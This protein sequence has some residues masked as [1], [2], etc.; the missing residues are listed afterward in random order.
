MSVIYK[1][2]LIYN[3]RE[4]LSLMMDFMLSLIKKEMSQFSFVSGGNFKFEFVF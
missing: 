2:D 1:C 3:G 4:W